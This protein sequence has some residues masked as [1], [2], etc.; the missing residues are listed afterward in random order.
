MTS[1]TVF[2][3]NTQHR[4]IHFVPER[5]FAIAPQLCHLWSILLSYNSYQV[6]NAKQE[7]CFLHI[8]FNAFANIAL[9]RITSTEHVLK[10][11]KTSF[12]FWLRKKL[13]VVHH[14][15]RTKRKIKRFH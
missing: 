5:S 14:A 8:I 11:K 2:E 7:K 3:L 6:D 4:F 13:A 15:Y 10:I 9:Q 1:Y 12:L